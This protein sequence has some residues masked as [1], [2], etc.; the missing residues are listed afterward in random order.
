VSFLGADLEGDPAESG[1]GDLDGYLSRWRPPVV[2]HSRRSILGRL[3]AALTA[4][5]VAVALPPVVRPTPAHPAPA[6][7]APITPDQYIAKARD[8]S[9]CFAGCYIGKH[10]DE[11]HAGV[12]EDDNPRD[13]AFTD[14]EADRRTRLMRAG[15]SGLDFWDRVSDRLYELGYRRDCM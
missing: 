13:R 12:I 6:L 8:R 3:A 7:V 9:A 14:K 15:R 4:A 2:D 10:R 5:P 1:I 11:I